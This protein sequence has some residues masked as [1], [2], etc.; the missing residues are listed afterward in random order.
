M[1]V[2][3]HASLGIAVL[4]AVC[5]G[6]ASPANAMSERQKQDPESGLTLRMADRDCADF[7]TQRAA[8]IF[9]LNNNPQSDPHR[10]DADG[11][12]VVCESL[13]CPCFYGSQPPN[14]TPPP[15]TQPQPTRPAKIKVVRVLNGELVKIREGTKKPVVVHL[16]GVD[17][18]KSNRCMWRGAKR[19]L[20]SWIKPGRVVR[21]AP[22][23]ASKK[24]DSGRLLA[25]LV[26]VRGDY[27][28]GGSQIA[29]G[30]GEVA[31]YRFS[32][33][34]RY[35]RWERQARAQILGAWGDCVPNSGAWNNPALPG[36]P[37]EVAGMRYTF[38][39][40][41][42]DAWPEMQAEKQAMSTGGPALYSES[43]EPG[44]TFVRVQVT[45]TN[46]GSTSAE[47]HFAD[48]NI[49]RG[50]AEYDHWGDFTGGWCG[51][52]DA[53]IGSGNYLSRGESLTGWVCATV[54][55]PLQAGDLWRVEP[56]L[57]QA[58]FVKV[59]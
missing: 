45:V 15:S 59:G 4:L 1:S 36:T 6:F 43:P 33:K 27:T 42:P 7:P 11:D 24:R 2:R 13:P 54:P 8:Q 38:G 10:L 28:I 34:S 16:M 47:P 48:F 3:R 46:V 40:T 31:K 51:T 5:L 30:W 58:R 17:V 14:S 9:F 29:T 12:M 35:A 53:Y 37:F 32:E 23:K 57:D 50:E 18:D 41:D 19:D 49:K 21:I 22:T 26:T 55:G 56:E 44:W 25:N 39:V 52:G 20:K